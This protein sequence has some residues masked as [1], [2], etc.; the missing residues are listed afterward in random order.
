MENALILAPDGKRAA[1]SLPA[2]SAQGRDIWLM[3]IARGLRTRFTFDAADELTTAWSPDSSRIVFSSRRKGHLDLYVKAS[4]GA[5][6]EEVLLADNL[7]KHPLSWS[8]DGRFLPYLSAGGPGRT[9]MW[10][11]PMSG[12]SAPEGRKPTPFRQTSFT[13]GPGFFAPDGRWVA[14]MSNESGQN[15]VYVAPFPGPG[16][17]W[18]V[19]TAGGTQPGW[20][21]DGK[22]LF[23]LAPDSTLMAAT[24][25]SQGATFEVGDVRPLFPVTP[26]GPRSFYQVSPDGQRF[27]VNRAPTND[28]APA[29]FTVVV[30]WTEG[31]RK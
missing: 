29:P 25:K 1:V 5:G 14:Y 15:Q 23:Y 2:G 6:D 20:G 10:V 7:E 16:E 24:V 17:K 31:L 27:L 28:A 13:E 12:T 3:D 26:G 4:S 30:N 21:S 18:I 8:P 19:S 11:L 22:E 9:D